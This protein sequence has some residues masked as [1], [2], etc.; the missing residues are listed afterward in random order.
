MLE[1]RD[2]HT[3][4]GDSYIL[5]GVSIQVPDGAVFAVLGRNGV[6]KTTLIRSI[7]GFTPPRRG[8]IIFNGDD[9]THLT[10][11]RIAKRGIGLVPQGRRIFPSLTVRENLM[12]AARSTSTNNDWRLPQVVEL[13]PVLGQRYSQSGGKLSGGEQQMLAIGRC[14]MGNPSLMLM[15][16]PTEGLAPL[17]LQ[18]LKSVVLGLKE[19]GISILLVE[20]NLNFALDIADHIYVMSR[21]RIVHESSPQELQQNEEAKHLYLGV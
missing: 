13:F 21:G 18:E 3:Y 8:H 10:P 6:G 11:E 4:Y 16:E 1:I 5:Q 7:I 2:I 19:K 12:V 15:D 17:I 14:L 9:I 20:Q